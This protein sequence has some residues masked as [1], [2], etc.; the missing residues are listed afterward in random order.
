[1][2]HGPCARSRGTRWRGDRARCD[3][4]GTRRGCSPLNAGRLA[5]CSTRCVHPTVLRLLNNLV[6]QVAGTVRLVNRYRSLTKGEVCRRAVDYGAKPE[7]LWDTVS[8]GHPHRQ[9]LVNCGRCY[10]CLVRRSGL[11]AALGHDGTP[12]VD[13]LEAIDINS[14]QQSARDL[15]AV[16]IWLTSIPSIDDVLSDAPLPPDVSAPAVLHCRTRH[17]RSW[18]T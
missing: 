12:Y 17:G 4:S 6:I 2:F 16:L 7:Q 10:P 15:R 8:C 5:A 1:M 18:Q 9:A 11:H 14:K 3:T 13:R